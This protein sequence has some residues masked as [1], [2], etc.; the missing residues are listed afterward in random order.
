M[1]GEADTGLRVGVLGPLRAWRGT[2]EIGL[3]PARQRAIFAVLAVNAG[4][5][6]PRA[7][8]IAG[9]WGD[10]A[11]ASVEGSVH[12]YVS[13][14]RR[15]LEP[16][17]S[18]WSAA[19][20]LVSD[21]AGY[22]LLLDEDALDAAVFERHRERARQHLDTGD[23]RAAVTEL[24]AALALWQG[25]ALS[26]VPG[27]FAERHREHLAELRLDTLERRV[28]ALLALGGHLD[29]APELAVLAGE[30]PL[31]E[32][33]RESLMLAL[34][35]SGR[36]AEALDVFRDARATLVDELGV[37]PGPALQRLQQQ[38]LA[39]DPVLDAPAAPVEV[40]GHRLFG[41]ETETARLAELVA[42]VRA[43][44]GRAV[45]I[46][47]EAGIGK[48]ELLTSSLPDG[49]GFQRLWAAADE[50]STRFPLQVMVECLAIDARSA[51]PRRARVGKELAGDPVRRSW[52]PADPVLGA[53]DRLL[54]L[55]DE[56]CADSPQVLVVD[57]LQWAD[58]ASVLVWHR[59]CAATRQLPLLLVAA[60]RPAP[61]RAELA[62]L[63]RGV[64]A[65]DGV[66]LDLAPLTGEDVGRL[67]ED[68]I[69]AAPGPGLR[70]LAA[71]GAGNPLYVK[72][73][74][75]VLVHAGAVEVTG[76]EA[77]VDDPEEFEA[78]PS[79]VA[80]VDRRLDFLPARTREVLRWGALLGM[81]F[82]VGDIAAVLGARPSDLLEPL[83]EAVAANVLVDTGTQLAFRHPLL[84]Q[85]L[86]DRLP[87]GTRAALHR[88]AAEALAGIGAPVKRVAEQLVAA[89]ATVDEWVLDWLA[90]HHAAVSNRAPLIAVELL[91][92]ALAAGAGPR[93]EVLLVALVKVL[94]RLERSPEELA[95]QALDVATEPDAVEEMRHVLAALRHRRGDTEGAVATLGASADDPAVPELWRVRHRQLLANFR[96]G[97]LSDLDTAEKAAYETKSLAGGDRY[98]TAHALQT[99][100]LVDS[101]RR[102]HDSALAHVDAAIE[103]V[104]DE[105]ELADLHLDLLDNRVF[106]LQ[107]LDR[108]AEAGEALR[109]AGE[110][111]ARHAMP[112]GLQ[113]SVAVHRY[114]EGR[115]DEALVELDTVTEDGP[116][117]TFYGLREPGPAALLLHGVAALIAGHRDDHAQAAAHLDAAEEYAP[118][119][120][121]E[122]ESFDF[123][124]VADALA[125]EQRGD[126]ARALA[127]LE[128]IL[129]PTYAQMMLRHQWLPTF[130]R[131]AMD[132]DDVER[133]RRALAVCEE[134]AAK[135]R[136]PAR[137]YAAA[138]W[139]RGLIEEDP[140][141]ALATAEHFR[142]VGRRPELAS[143][144]EDAAVLLAR[145]G[146]LDAAHAAFEE[147]AELFTALGAR[148]DLRRAETRLRRLGVRRGALFA[149]IRPGHGWE[150]LTP[151][152]I[153]IASLVA[154]GRSNP[155]IAAELSL[156]RR[157]VQAHVTR[158]LGK[159]ETPSRSG[160][161]DAFRNRP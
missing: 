77:D 38:I 134:E 56:L 66:V 24:D 75:D 71:R 119:T 79:L 138:S 83:E 106:T 6:V 126:R 137:A 74:V 150:S 99:L 18:R 35:R 50:L 68:Q 97:D 110:V 159:L 144:L 92:R 121:A 14:L 157:T 11:P 25:E 13:G 49:P 37:E 52:G 112:V 94:F 21:P 47:G 20:V 124:L 27:G 2:A 19:S 62:Q 22:S 155:D 125:A 118:A 10:A 108:L 63:R 114:W 131:L 73:M 8:L 85:A 117:I 3:G 33:L 84:R 128:P 154:E 104:G 7:E 130:V 90:G 146:R 53:V 147:A 153:R 127:V 9:V 41:R 48:S 122:R 58:E 45:W 87:A 109:M 29:L 148:W 98:L 51:D 15:A 4:R 16:D 76:G 86:Y 80:A 88:Q 70:E 142:A 107:N 120:S 100:W 64:L 89:P 39:Q 54:A 1:R 141:A 111:A 36:H 43:G 67:I 65:R 44:R 12:T 32:S 151:I 145:E 91:E 96:R 135:E 59:L 34:Y 143:V 101:V 55:V 103:A 93:R 28:E 156:P 72:E 60:T 116:A 46:E 81:E 158:L 5:P 136:R 69:G 30:H 17:R 78:P 160:V 82:A 57:D 113:V 152:E 102:E 140:A 129:N 115:W 149:S 132:Q 26:G 61:D 23:P 40:T 133:A 123:L 105:H 161:A 42:D 95:R 139:C 31:R